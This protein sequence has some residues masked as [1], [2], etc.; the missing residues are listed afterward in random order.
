ML[1]ARRGLPTILTGAILLERASRLRA[2]L[3]AATVLRIC[4]RRLLAILA[5]ATLV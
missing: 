5:T 2:T 1:I 4:A 3:L